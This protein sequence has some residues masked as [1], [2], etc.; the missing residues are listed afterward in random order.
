MKS[1][2]DRFRKPLSKPDSGPALRI[3][4]GLDGAKLSLEGGSTGL[5]TA[6]WERRKPE[7][8]QAVKDVAT[9]AESAANPASRLDV[10][11]DAVRLS[12]ALVRRLTPD[13]ERRLGLPPPTSLALEVRGQGGIADAGFHITTQWVRPGGF[14]VE[15]EQ[16]GCFVRQSGAWR[17]IPNAT[18]ELLD[19][20]EP[21]RTPTSREQRFQ[22]LDGLGRVWPGGNPGWLNGDPVLGSIRVYYA[23]RMSL[24]VRELA[25]DRTDFDPVLFG[26]AKSEPEGGEERLD[27]VEDSLLP[28]AAQKLFAENRFRR[29]RRG[30]DVYL[31]SDGAYVFV[32]PPLLPVLDLVRQAQDLPPGAKRAFLLDPQKAIREHLKLEGDTADADLAALFVET[33]QFSER[34]AGV[35]LWRKQVLPWLAPS[36]DNAWLPE[37]F[38]LRIDGAYYAVKPDGLAD[39]FDQIDRASSVAEPLVTVSGLLEP[40]GPDGPPP[41]GQIALTPQTRSA[42]EALRSL[43]AD[44]PED[45]PRDDAG[46]G[47]DEAA[48]RH[49]GPLFLVVKENF[50]E[51]SFATRAALEQATPAPDLVPPTVPETVAATLKSHQREGLTWLTRCVRNGRPGALLCDDMGLG[52]T[53]QALA[54]MAWLQSVAQEEGAACRILIVAPTGLLANWKAEIQRHLRGERL[55]RIVEAFG[56]Q[57]KLLRTGPGTQR[58]T[59]SGEAGLDLAGWGSRGVVLTTYETLRDYHFS[60]A[61]QYFDLIV[62]DEAQKLKNPTSQLTRSAKTLRGG[63]SLGMTG[64]P[65]E[66]RMQDLWSLFDV[67]APGLLGA[68]RDFERQYTADNPAALRALKSQLCDDGPAAPAWLLRRMKS[69][70]LEGLPAKHFHR[71]TQ[72]MPPFQAEAYQQVLMRASALRTQGLGQQGMLET[73]ALLRGCSLHPVTPEQ[74]GDDLARY[75]ALSARMGATLQVLEAIQAKG[76]KALIFLEDRAMQ[77]C[78]ARLLQRHFA[79]PQPPAI[80]NGATPGQTRQDLVDRFQAAPAGFGVMILSPKAGGVGLTLT[81]ANHVIHLSRWWNPAVEDQATDR[82]FRI[83]QER[84][85]HVYIPQAIHPDPSIRG[86]SFDL[87]LDALIDRKRGLTRDLFLPPLPSDGELGDLLREVTERDDS[88]DRTQSATGAPVAAQ[89]AGEAA[90]APP[91]PAPPPAPPPPAA[92]AP[93]PLP[94]QAPIAPSSR[95]ILTLRTRPAPAPRFFRIEPGRPR[96]VADIL[97]PFTGTAIAEVVISDPYA[98]AGDQERAAQAWF[99]GQLAKIADGIN[100]V[101]IEYDDSRIDA[102]DDSLARRDMNQRALEAMAPKGGLVRLRRRSG[103]GRGNDFHDRSVTILTG[104]DTG[105]AI[106]H[107]LHLGRGLISLAESRFE[108]SLTHVQTTRIQA[109]A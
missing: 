19:A 47:A 25:P 17:R 5:S 39:V 48:A 40:V 22:A 97:A 85:V 20:I 10:L 84:D 88:Q 35:D 101:T 52:K 56:N 58:D 24:K 74:A 36:G 49:R 31:L 27:E 95:P 71:I 7:L 102:P 91:P 46:A 50:E 53:L 2:F 82:A 99:L 43:V 60:F 12:H 51:V 28:P 8:W 73:L 105:D 13:L 79:L 104:Q 32:D 4:I 108:L 70:V 86:H 16:T 107:E 93:S 38:G 45:G 106:R 81:A 54:F 77:G 9:F 72:D 80:I 57:L 1:L 98:L 67:L 44:R 42:F 14:P 90:A 78:L 61:T 6:D 96:P 18:L 55:G 103:R 30:R 34:I 100:A 15:G 41:P 89:A 68:S 59:R 64:T 23:A 63:F 37:R 87:R 62:F 94:V 76:E 3:E 65:V 69:E 75:A 21:L 29:D 33:A 26:S 83:G 109:A 92:Q 66:N 11:P